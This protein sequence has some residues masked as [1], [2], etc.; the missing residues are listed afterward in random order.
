MEVS[1][2]RYFYEVAKHQSFTKAAKSLRVSQPAISKM[3]RQLEHA[4]DVQLFHRDKRRSTLTDIGKLYFE[5]CKT[6][7]G[8]IE[9]LKTLTREHQEECVGTLAIGASD[10]LCNYWLPELLGRFCKTH[11]KVNV[12]LLSGTSSEIKNAIL[13]DA[14][15]CGLFYTPLTTEEER[16]LSLQTLRWVEFVL[17]VSSANK[18]VGRKFRIEDFRTGI[19]YIGSRAADYRQAYPALK[20][21]QILGLEPGRFIE[22]NNQETQKRLVLANQG[23]TIVPRHMVDA[24]L[25]RG[26][27]RQVE[28][29]K[30]IGSPVFFARKKNR[31]LSKVARAFR[32]HLE[33]TP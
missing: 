32:E 15:E 6:I 16:T 28:L 18:T 20:M 3:I 9:N 5:R 27:L 13:D 4:N 29:P 14:L 8:E 31:V 21:H 22:T 11:S 10:N 25:K 19:R 24:E 12:R 26:T 7:F 17:V 30:K 33:K 23:Y 1:H 2:L